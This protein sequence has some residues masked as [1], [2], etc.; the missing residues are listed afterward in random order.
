M[1]FSSLVNRIA[2]EGVD[3]WHIQSAA[4]AAAERGE[5][6]IVL[7]VGDPDFATPESITESAVQA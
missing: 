3:A 4:L 1:K 2:G 5:D 7:S 6:V